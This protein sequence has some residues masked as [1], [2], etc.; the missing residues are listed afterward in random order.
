MIRVEKK[1][2]YGQILGIIAICALLYLASNYSVDILQKIFNQENPTIS[3]IYFNRILLWGGLF[4]FFLYVKFYLKEKLV[5]WKEQNLTIL[6]TVIS[7]IVIMVLLFVGFVGLILIIQSMDFATQVEGINEIRDLTL[8]NIPLLIFT[9]VT[10][11]IVEEILFRGYILPTLTEIT[12][13]AKL[14]V[15]LSSTLF[16]F[17]HFSYGTAHQIIIPIYFGIVF[18]VYYVK[19]RNIKVVILCHFIWNLVSSLDSAGLL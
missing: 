1:K 7:I 19:Y 3:I 5:P 15:L 14:G 17:M 10:A 16:G 11:A 2:S 6:Q 12:N 4:L 9:C 18:S 8:Q 13:S